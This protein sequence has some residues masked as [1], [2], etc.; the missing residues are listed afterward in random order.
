MAQQ[1]A[2]AKAPAPLGVAAALTAVEAVVLVLYGLS[3]LPEL[4]AERLVAGLTALIFFLL[5]GG[6]LAFAAWQVYRLESWARAPI[7]LAQLIQFALGATW[8]DAVMATVLI[9]PTLV[10][11]V[12]LFHPAS[13]AA[14]SE[15]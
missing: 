14:L 11:A 9:V 7:M 6:F 12:G 5:Y 4:H 2:D 1:S 15:E 13:L 3:L 8:G 10:V